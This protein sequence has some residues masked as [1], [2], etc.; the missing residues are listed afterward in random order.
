RDGGVHAMGSLSQQNRRRRTNGADPARGRC[1][2]A[3]AL[4]MVAAFLFPQVVHAQ[5]DPAQYIR[6]RSFSIPFSATPGARPIKEVRLYASE[7]PGSVWKIEGN[8]LPSDKMFRFTAPRDGL[9][10]FTVQTID[11]DNRAYPARLDQAEVLQKVIVDTRPPSVSLRQLPARSDGI[12]I[13][14]VARDENLDVNTLV[15][16]FRT[17]GGQW[18]LVN[19]EKA[20]SGQVSW[21]PRGNGPFEV[22]MQVRD[23]AGNLGQDVRTVS[24]GGGTGGASAGDYNDNGSGGGSNLLPKIVNSRRISL[25]YEIRQKGKSGISVVDLY[26]F[27]YANRKWDKY[28]QSLPEKGPFTVEVAKEGTWGFTLIAHSGVGLGDP[29]PRATD[30]PQV[31][32]EVDETK[33]D[34]KIDIPPVVGTGVETGYL[35]INWKATD[36]KPLGRQP[37]TISYAEKADGPWQPIKAN[38]ENIGRYV[39]P[40]PDGLPFQFYV[41]VEC[42]DRAGNVGSAITQE[43]VKVDL[44][45]PKISISA[46]DVISADKASG[47]TNGKQND[48]ND[49]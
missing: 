44:V 14:W 49:R 3:L 38:L 46:I 16:E 5:A 40:M 2:W 6:N 22:R 15:L 28:E 18:Q 26:I 36:N 24:L 23:R 30:I 7:G 37:I 19:C 29:P 10:W 39:W 12:S 34:V 32:I 47:G 4:G 27:D 45:V 31:S 25:N 9:Y 41:K 1:T 13:E 8:A 43:T 42:T 48:Y 11:V 17:P 21:N 35:T 20:E 33:P